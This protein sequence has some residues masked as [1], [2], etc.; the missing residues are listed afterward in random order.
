MEGKLKMEIDEMINP[1]ALGLAVLI[2]GIFIV[3]IWKVPTWDTYPT[4]YKII[5]SIVLPI[6]SYFIVVW[7]M[8]ND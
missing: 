3:M 7:R 2:S 6:I 1:L 8:G 4:K 5:M